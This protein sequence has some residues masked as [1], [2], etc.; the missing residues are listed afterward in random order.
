M[1]KGPRYG[2]RLGLTAKARNITERRRQHAQEVERMRGGR[3]GHQQWR[4]DDEDGRE[5]EDDDN[6]D[7][8]DRTPVSCENSLL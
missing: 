3:M 8:D 4:V 6:H 2:F 5:D 1:S 7:E